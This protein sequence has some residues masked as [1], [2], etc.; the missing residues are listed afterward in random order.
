MSRAPRLAHIA[1]LQRVRQSVIVTYL[2]VAKHPVAISIAEDAVAL[3]HKHLRLLAPAEK[4]PKLDLFLYSRGGDVSVPWRIVTMAREFADEFN[5]LV[6]YHSHSAATM[7]CLGA[8]EIVM[9]KKGELSPIDPTLNRLG[10]GTG[11]PAAVNVED[12]MSYLAFMRDKVGIRDQEALG[13]L[14]GQLATHVGP[15]TLGTVN[16]QYS[17]IRLVARK[18][19][20]LRSTKMWRRRS[21]AIIRTL[22]EKMY[23]HGHAI[24]R[25]EAAELGLPVKNATTE[26]EAAMWALYQDYENWLKPADP[27]DSEAVLMAAGQE[28]L[29]QPDVPFAAIESE[30]RLDVFE[31]NLVHR[32]KR[33]VPPNP[34]INVNVNLALP[35]GLAPGAVPP[36]WQQVLQQ[37]VNQVSQAVPGLVHQEIVRQSPVVGFELRGFGGRW[38]E[39]T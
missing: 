11:S 12:V 10:G 30:K 37:L 36:N 2:T 17:H 1:E 8:D 21:S 38:I 39:R 7:I 9:G 22:I 13:E 33:Q 34:Q 14:I 24:G 15:L 23:S 3:L 29:T 28:E 4:L 16:R 26:E 25:H 18:L 31:M 27:I 5:V 6:P 20:N 32:R 19:L 35:P